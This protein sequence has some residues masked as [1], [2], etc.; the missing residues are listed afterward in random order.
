[1]KKNI[2]LQDLC[3]GLP[4]EVIDYMNYAKY[5]KFEQ[6]PDYNYLKNLFKRILKRNGVSLDNYILSWCRV[7]NLNLN[8]DSKDMSYKKNSNGTIKRKSSPQN[9]LYKK[10][11]E[12]IENKNKSLT[13]IILKSARNKRKQQYGR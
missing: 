10:I 13:N 12:S 8:S 9:R 6:E 1:M 5:L 3:K 2:K 4:S 11:Q 7:E